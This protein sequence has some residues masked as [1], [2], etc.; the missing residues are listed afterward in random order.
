[1]IQIAGC[2]GLS[3]F[4][5]EILSLDKEGIL[6]KELVEVIGVL[7][8]INPNSPDFTDIHHKLH[9]VLQK[10]VSS[11]I[12]LPALL[13]LFVNQILQSCLKYLFAPPPSPE[14]LE[15]FYSSLYSS[16]LSSSTQLCWLIEFITS[17]EVKFIFLH[18]FIARIFKNIVIIFIE[19]HFV[20]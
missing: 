7:Q 1:M 16:I 9:Y 4:V 13:G 17:S 6:L 14:S 10:I 15:E 8:P 3:E 19:T 20:K 18:Y 12:Y 2:R 11:K 5:L